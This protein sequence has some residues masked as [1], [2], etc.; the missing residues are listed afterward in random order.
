MKTLFTCCD[1]KYF[2]N[3]GIKLLNSVLVNSNTHM[4]MHVV[5]PDYHDQNK[6]DDINLSWD[7]LTLTS[8]IS[9]R[10]DR[11][12]YAS[13]RFMIAPDFLLKEYEALFLIDTDCLLLKEF[14]FPENCDYGLFLRDPLPGTV[15]IEWE[16]THC[17]AGA[18]Y[19]A[20]SGYRFIRA[21]ASQLIQLKDLPWFIDQV[22]LYRTHLM[23][24]DSLKFKQLDSS[25]I[26]WEFKG[27]SVIWTGKGPRK[28]NNPTYVNKAIGYENYPITSTT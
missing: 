8:H 18:V 26:D 12:Y 19:V 2:N 21:V 7:Q 23:Y 28:F 24:E 9:N 10:T 4:H 25:L 16:G 3:H 14:P 15:G 27:D 17:A 5:N 13:A 1:G 20:Q 11:A 22:I 6:I